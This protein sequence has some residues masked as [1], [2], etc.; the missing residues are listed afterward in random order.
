MTGRLLGIARH[1]RPRGPMETIDAATVTPSL[2]IHG[3]HRGAVK[4]GGKG[5]R[6]VTV[7]TRAAWDAAMAD[8][9][10]AQPLDWWVRRANLLVDGIDLPREAG[11]RLLFA[12]GVVLEITGECDPCR[13]MDEIAPGLQD[14][15][16][17]DWRGGI[18]ARVLAGGELAIGD[19]VR[20]GTS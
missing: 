14:A 17:P 20:I 7:I 4:P 10:L 3:D 9:G 5:R 11:A 12:G 1:D 6:Q 2:G 15:L 13:R 8:L 16:V 19:E 18:T